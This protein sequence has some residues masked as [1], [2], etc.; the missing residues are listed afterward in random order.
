MFSPRTIQVQ[1]LCTLWMTASVLRVIALSE[2]PTSSWFT[3]V[4]GFV[5][6]GVGN[7]RPSMR[8]KS[9]PF[10]FLLLLIRSGRNTCVCVSRLHFCA[11]QLRM[12]S[13]FTSAEMRNQLRD[14]IALLEFAIC[15]VFVH[16]WVY[17]EFIY[18]ASLIAYKVI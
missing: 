18:S 15:Q 9:E 13:M 2:D 6:A 7:Y 4:R 16:L 12:E 5:I 3:S 8:N 14:R 10:W 1:R 17:L 11:A